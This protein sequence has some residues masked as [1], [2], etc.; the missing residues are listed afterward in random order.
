MS[1]AAISSSFTSSEIHALHLILQHKVNSSTKVNLSVCQFTLEA[2]FI[3][4]RIFHLTTCCGSCRVPQVEHSL[5]KLNTCKKVY[6][7]TW[8]WM[9]KHI[10]FSCAFVGELTFKISNAH[11]LMQWQI[12]SEV[13]RHFTLCTRRTILPFYS[14]FWWVNCVKGKASM[15]QLLNWSHPCSLNF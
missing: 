2:P 3:S 6:S 7:Y 14:T 12:T 4:H 1:H 10:I 8:L 5:H 9:M 11:S 15:N 13:S